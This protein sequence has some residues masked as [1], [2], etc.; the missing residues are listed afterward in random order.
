[1]HLL[2]S[3]LKFPQ[4]PQPAGMSLRLWL[5][6]GELATR[7]LLST[8]NGPK[9]FPNAQTWSCR[10]LEAFDTDSGPS[11]S[12]VP[13]RIRASQRS[14]REPA[15][16]SPRPAHSFLILPVLFTPHPEHTAPEHGIH[17]HPPESVG[18]RR[19]HP[20]TYTPRQLMTGGTSVLMERDR[21]RRGVRPCLPEQEL[22]SQWE[23]GVTSGKLY[24]LRRRN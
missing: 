8:S 5:F 13:C 7:P 16:P 14:S 22:E 6:S 18:V 23:R 10:G 12:S 11:A 2:L 21:M 1:M 9:A 19:T 15:R 24:P 3:R 4:S 20:L 17:S